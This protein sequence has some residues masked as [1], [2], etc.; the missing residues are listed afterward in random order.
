M[1]NYQKCMGAVVA[2]VGVL[3]SQGVAAQYYLGVEAG[4]EH[5]DFEPKYRFV[6]GTPNESFENHANGAALGLLGGYHLLSTKDY[7]LAVQGRLS[8]SNAD[9]KLRLDEPASLR[10]DLPMNVAVSLL[11]TFRLSEKFSVFAEV[12]LALG[13][14]R[15][16][17]STGNVNS[18]SYHEDKW[19]P[20]MVAG[21]GLSFALDE[22]WSVRAGY[23][24][25][26][27]KDHDFNTYRANGT[28]VERVT[29][30]VEQSST[31]LAL[32]RAF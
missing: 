1:L 12:G 17:K 13:K 20:G 9:W 24:R 28:Q 19:R 31:T 30:R 14:I 18:S 5:L 15:E 11:P 16:H 22:R 27:Y 3:A 7:A 2:V 29:S 6:N 8:V 26:W 4:H 23:R 21:L 32:I 25:T 10:Y